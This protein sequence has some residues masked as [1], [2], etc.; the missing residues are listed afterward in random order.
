MKNLILASAFSFVSVFN[1]NVYAQKGLNKGVNFRLIG[2]NYLG[3]NLPGTNFEKSHESNIG[4]T[5][6]KFKNGFAYG[7]NLRYGLNDY[8]D[9]ESGIT[10][11]YRF[12]E[13]T[14]FNEETGIGFGM[15]RLNGFVE[16]P[17]KLSHR[18]S[19]SKN[20]DLNLIS[21]LGGAILFTYGEYDEG[22]D[23]IVN[24]EPSP[25]MEYYLNDLAKSLV[26]SFGIEKPY[27]NRGT[28]YFGVSYHY[29]FNKAAKY[30]V[31]DESTF[32]TTTG[33]FRLSYL[34]FEYKYYLPWCTKIW[35]L[36][37]K[38]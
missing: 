21:S 18:K 2:D 6:G 14:D 22:G 19:I 30:Y 28:S 17:L 16:I 23:L 26:I 13:L 24:G 29:N 27:K 38:G 31:R 36:Q 32:Q 10:Q 33:D 8:L 5:E 34:S 25:T 3:S 15:S 12:F 4:Y 7:L 1:S 37:E 20:Y 9:L 11:G 35:K